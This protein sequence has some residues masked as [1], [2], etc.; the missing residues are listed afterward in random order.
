MEEPST[1]IVSRSRIVGTPRLLATVGWSRSAIASRFTGAR[2]N[3][4]PT[5]MASAT[6]PR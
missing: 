2:A 6:A 3:Q 1:N 5:S 4:S